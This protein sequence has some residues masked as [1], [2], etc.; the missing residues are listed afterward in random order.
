VEQKT[1]SENHP[2]ET[3]AKPQRNSINVLLI[4]RQ[5]GAEI[6]LLIG[7]W[8]QLSLVWCVYSVSVSMAKMDFALTFSE[9][10]RSLQGILHCNIFT[11]LF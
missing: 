8:P 11:G 5:N 10:P 2:N 3:S 9:L 1:E 6:T 4:R 7:K